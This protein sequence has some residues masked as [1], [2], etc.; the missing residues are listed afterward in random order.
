MFIRGSLILLKLIKILLILED[1]NFW[2]DLSLWVEWIVY[3][4]ELV[5]R[6][7]VGVDFI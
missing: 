7:V 2:L 5:L 6:K 3:V 4:S 1:M